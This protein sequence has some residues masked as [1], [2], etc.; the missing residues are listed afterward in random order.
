VYLAELA[1]ILQTL[2]VVRMLP[3]DVLIR[4]QRLL[5]LA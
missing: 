1:E 5:Q 3:L 4:P 2:D